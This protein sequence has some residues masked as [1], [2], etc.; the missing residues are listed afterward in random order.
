MNTLYREHGY[1]MVYCEVRGVNC[2]WVR[3]DELSF[4]DVIKFNQETTVMDTIQCAKYGRGGH[5]GD[6]TV[7]NWWQQ[8]VEGIEESFEIR[9][10]E[11]SQEQLNKKRCH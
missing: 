2:F 10:F 4:D 3:N 5:R 6:L 9:R 7:T 8:I 11:M 1:S